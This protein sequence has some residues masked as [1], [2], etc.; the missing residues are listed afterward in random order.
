MAQVLIETG[1]GTGIPAEIIALFAAVIAAIIGFLKNED[2]YIGT[3]AAYVPNAA[4]DL[5]EGAVLRGLPASEHLKCH[6]S[7]PSVAPL[8]AD[9]PPAQ[10]HPSSHVSCASSVSDT[11]WARSEEEGSV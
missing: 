3:Y 2:D 5:A 11:A 9:V 4:N 10:N 8:K 1:M 7:A 6:Q